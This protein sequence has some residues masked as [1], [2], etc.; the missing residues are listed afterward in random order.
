[1]N[2]VQKDRAR[3]RGVR[4][5]CALVAVAL[6]AA[7]LVGQTFS[8]VVRRTRADNVLSFGGVTIRLNETML[9]AEGEEVPVPAGAEVI[10]RDAASSRIVRVENVGDHPAYVRVRLR[11]TGTDAS[12]AVLP[13]DDIVTYRRDGVA[14]SDAWIE[15]GG[16]YYYARAL[17]PGQTTPALID[18]VQLDAAAAADRF[19]GGTL[20]LDIDAGAVQSENNAASACDAEGWPQGDE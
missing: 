19:G 16:W 1:M 10:A 8:S 12:G 14:A 7:V 5:A 18:G 13:A 9:D 2:D 4:R 6:V 20:T 15:Q 11:M 3:S 17:E